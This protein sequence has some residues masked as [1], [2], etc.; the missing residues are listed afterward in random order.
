MWLVE[1]VDGEVNRERAEGVLDE[2]DGEADQVDVGQ[3]GRRGCGFSWSGRSG[4][5]GIVG[6]FGERGWRRVG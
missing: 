2:V 3:V 5:D 1:L 6:V 4:R